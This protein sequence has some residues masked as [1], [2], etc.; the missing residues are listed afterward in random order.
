M[1]G[2]KKEKKKVET[3]V[4]F[5]ALPQQ[6]SKGCP[7]KG[8]NFLVAE[9]LPAF[10]FSQNLGGLNINVKIKYLK[11]MGLNTTLWLCNANCS[12]F[13]LYTC[14]AVCWF[15]V[16]HTEILVGMDLCKLPRPASHFQRDC[17]LN[18]SHVTCDF[19]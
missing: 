19:I 15:P 12:P 18:L 13:P 11:F 17:L 9:I 6:I 5:P 8:E 16:C 7:E 1:Y 4:R 14:K 10:R 2:D 3:F